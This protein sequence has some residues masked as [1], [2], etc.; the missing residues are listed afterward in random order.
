M[1]C[2]V[3]SCEDSKLPRGFMRRSRSGLTL[4]LI[5]EIQAD[6]ALQNSPILGGQKDKDKPQPDPDAEDFLKC[7]LG[8][9]KWKTFYARLSERRLASSRLRKDSEEESPG[10]V[11]VYLFLLKVE[12]VKEVLR[13][14]VP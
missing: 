6:D 8:D 1:S 11:S 10:A 3:R 14:L 5:G 13:T 7:K 12:C 4:L 2:V 9:A